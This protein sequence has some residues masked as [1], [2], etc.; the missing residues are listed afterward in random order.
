MLLRLRHQSGAVAFVTTEKDAVNLGGHLSRLQPVH[1][2]PVRMQLEPAPEA[3]TGEVD[4]AESVAEAL[5]GVIAR[6]NQ[7]HV[8]E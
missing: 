4:A 8:R 2:V 3:T 6:H 1:V 7:T 5:S